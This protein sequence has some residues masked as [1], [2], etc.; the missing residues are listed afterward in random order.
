[1]ADTETQIQYDAEG[2]V[3]GE[4]AGG[5]GCQGGR[6]GG[7]LHGREAARRR[8]ICRSINFLLRGA[9]VST[10]AAGARLRVI[11]ELRW[12]NK[13]IPKNSSAQR[14]TSLLYTVGDDAQFPA[15]LKTSNNCTVP[16]N[17]SPSCLPQDRIIHHVSGLLHSFSVTASRFTKFKFQQLWLSPHDSGMSDFFFFS[18]FNILVHFYYY[19]IGI[20]VQEVKFLTFKGRWYPRF[21]N[22]FQ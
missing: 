16:I 14:T 4:Q 13:A 7:V 1:M 2:E 9:W 8:H 20:Y 6:R 10:L 15:S 21:S 19:K 11:L 18:A 3:E 5:G 22:L 17:S 12:R